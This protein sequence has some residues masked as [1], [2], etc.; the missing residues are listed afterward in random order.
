MKNRKVVSMLKLSPSFEPS[1]CHLIKLGTLLKIVEFILRFDY[2]PQASFIIILT[3]LIEYKYSTCIIELMNETYISKLKPD[4]FEDIA[5][6][7]RVLDL[8]TIQQIM[9]KLN[10][11]SNGKELVKYFK[12]YKS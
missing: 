8:A 4:S 11:Y 5:H 12:S 3:K 6:L 9:I 2:E 7:I 10:T 1:L